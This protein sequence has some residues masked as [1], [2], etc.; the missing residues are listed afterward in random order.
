MIAA[1]LALLSGIK[2]SWKAILTALMALAIFMF[3]NA[4]WN[5]VEGMQNEVK[6]LQGALTVAV[7]EKD[8]ALARSEALSEAQAN[9]ARRTEELN[10]ER[11]RAQEELQRTRETLSAIDLEKEINNDA[12]LALSRLNARTRELNRMLERSS[13]FREPSTDRR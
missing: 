2:I 8:T 4:A 12:A 13:R 10:E 7:I 5:W 1:A 6:T 11:Q 9:L 3:V